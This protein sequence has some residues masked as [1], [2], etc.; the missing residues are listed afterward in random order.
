[1]IYPENQAIQYLVNHLEDDASA[2]S[3][4]WQKY[5]RDFKV[6]EELDISGIIGFGGFSTEYTG[7]RK[8]A[9][10]IL[11]SKFRK[12]GYASPG[13]FSVDIIAAEMTKI[14]N[15]GYDLDVLRQSLTLSFLMNKLENQNWFSKDRT[16]AVIGDGFCSMSLL[17][18]LT[19]FAKKVVLVNLSKT[20]LVDLIFLKKYIDRKSGLSFALIQESPNNTEENSFDLVA[21]QA[22]RHEIIQ[23]MPID[24]FINIASMQE[25]DIDVISAYFQDMREVAKKQDSYFY[26]CNRIEK[27]FPDGTTVRFGDYPWSNLDQV[28]VDEL[29]PWHQKYYS[30]KP[31]FYHPY[32]G[33]IQ[34]RLIKIGKAF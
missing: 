27:T 2:T 15:R 3:S 28:I 10:R 20:L 6:G 30:L 8:W 29:C 18:L 1:M 5:H 21:L 7:L 32:D 9:H 13:F 11:Q 26:C 19:G 4:H 33:P 12:F 23:S 24:L 17:L 14:Q 25:M 34:H 16:V 31:P 22:T